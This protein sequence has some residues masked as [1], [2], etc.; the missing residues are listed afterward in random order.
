[1]AGL[2]RHG[3][4]RDRRPDAPAPGRGPSPGGVGWQIAR[5]QGFT[6]TFDAEYL[7]VTRRQADA[8]VTVDPA[9]RARGVV[10]LG[11]VSQLSS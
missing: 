4:L 1:V 11:A 3:A 9:A 8:F 2:R 7:A 5:E 6:S 10:P